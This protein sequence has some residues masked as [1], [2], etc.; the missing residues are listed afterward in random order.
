MRLSIGMACVILA[1]SGLITEAGTAELVRGP[2]WAHVLLDEQLFSEK[3]GE[4]FWDDV[5]DVAFLKE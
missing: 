3:D 2:V 5:E 4:C 1:V